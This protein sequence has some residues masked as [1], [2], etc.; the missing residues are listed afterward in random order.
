M[1]ACIAYA[2][3]VAFS[4]FACSAQL[5]LTIDAAAAADI[6]AALRGQS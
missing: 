6:N 2:I 5:L 1:H 3:P 4:A